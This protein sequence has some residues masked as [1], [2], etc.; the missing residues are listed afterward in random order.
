[1]EQI[2]NFFTGEA[3][4]NVPEYQPDYEQ[5]LRLL[6]AKLERECG[7]TLNEIT[8]IQDFQNDPQNAEIWGLA[9]KAFEHGNFNELLASQLQQVTQENI[10]RT[11]AAELEIS[12]HMDMLQRQI[13]QAQQATLLGIG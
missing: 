11:Y 1:M 10:T 13:Q 5:G 12:M 7:I 4:S 2:M 9:R 6:Q 3:P 8:P